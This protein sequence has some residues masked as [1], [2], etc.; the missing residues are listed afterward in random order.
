[1][2]LSLSLSLSL[3]KVIRNLCL[4]IFGKMQV[5]IN[6]QRHLLVTKFYER[7]EVS[8]R[9]AEKPWT[10][11]SRRFS[12]SMVH[13][14][15]G[16]CILTPCVQMNGPTWSMES[17][18]CGRDSTHCETAFSLV[19]QSPAHEV[20]K[21]SGGTGTSIVRT[22]QVTESNTFKNL[23]DIFSRTGRGGGEQ[24]QEQDVKDKG[25]ESSHQ[26]SQHVYSQATRPPR[27]PRCLPWCSAVTS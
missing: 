13:C 9:D 3:H 24:G 27:T 25:R 11:R 19:P 1:M 15:R 26:R 17:R 12:R 8:S 23:A 5:A 18:E 14:H 21:R 2:S 22:L 20:H 7:H 6:A 4:S 10:A 16:S